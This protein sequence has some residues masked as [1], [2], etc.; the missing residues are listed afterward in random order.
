MSKS[1]GT[2]RFLAF[3]NLNPFFLVSIPSFIPFPFILHVLCIPSLWFPL[4]FTYSVFL[5]SD[6][7]YPSVFCIPS[8]WFPFLLIL[9]I[10]FFLY[11]SL[12]SNPPFQ[13]K[14]NCVLLKTIYISCS[15]LYLVNIF[16]TILLFPFLILTNVSF[17]ELY[18]VTVF[19]PIL[20]Y[21]LLII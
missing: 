18:L 11:P 13:I 12:K 9:C 8:L 4:S 19:H 5:L 6:F 16:H 14:L 20:P 3:Q 2:Y 10:L 21:L 7:H 17:C 15:K 1:W